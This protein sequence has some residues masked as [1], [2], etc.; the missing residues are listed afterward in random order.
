MG[1]LL[2]FVYG[3]ACYIVLW[4]TALYCIGF[5]GDIYVPGPA[6]LTGYVTGI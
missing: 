2:V 3:I 1:R 6:A 4:S 5:V